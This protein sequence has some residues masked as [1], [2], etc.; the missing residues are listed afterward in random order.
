MNFVARSREGIHLQATL[1]ISSATSAHEPDVLPYHPITCSV[2]LR[3]EGDGRLCCDH[4]AAPP[5][6]TRT[7]FC[8]DD[9]VAMLLI[10]L[11]HEL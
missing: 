4:A 6:D 10:E 8:I 3:F 5:G 11:S 9:S 2:G 7:Q 1:A